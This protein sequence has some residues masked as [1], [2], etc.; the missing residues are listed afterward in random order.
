[1]EESN[2][3]PVNSPVTVSCI[4][5]LW[6]FILNEAFLG[7]GLFLLCICARDSRGRVTGFS[8]WCVARFDG[9]IYRCNVDCALD[10]GVVLFNAKAIVV[11]KCNLLRF[12]LYD[13]C[14]CIIGLL[15]CI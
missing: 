7:G 2:V 5:S 3:Q 13:V 12:H 8:F 14:S 11:A 15:P 10:K 6:G 1:V 9:S 4:V